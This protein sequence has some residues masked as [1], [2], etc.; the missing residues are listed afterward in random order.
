MF[1]ILLQ[2]KYGFSSFFLMFTVRSCFIFIIFSIDLQ[3]LLKSNDSSK[4]L[5]KT[6]ISLKIN[7]NITNSYKLYLLCFPTFQ[8]ALNFDLY[9]SL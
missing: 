2:K 8:I 9:N 3:Y 6:V 7:V 1:L 5:L 4:L